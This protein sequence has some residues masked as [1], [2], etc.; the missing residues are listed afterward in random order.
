M[1]YRRIYNQIGIAIGTCPATGY[2]YLNFS[3][4]YTNSIYSKIGNASGFSYNLVQPLTRIIDAGYSFTEPRVDVKSLGEYGTITR[5]A[6]ATPPI[7]LNFSYYLMG[8]INEARM[9]FLFNTYSGN[10]P[11]N[12]LIYS[13]NICPVSALLDRTYQKNYTNSF[14]NIS[15]LNE[16]WLNNHRDCKNI[17]I[18]TNISDSDLNYL[19]TITQTLNGSTGK[20]LKDNVYVYA[21]GNC[22]L[23]NYKVT[24]AVGNFPMASVQYTCYNVM[25]QSGGSG[26]NIPSVN[27]SDFTLKTGTYNLPPM[28]TGRQATVLLPGDITLDISQTGNITSVSNLPIDF[29][30]IKIQNFD[31]ELNLNR[32]PLQNLGYKLPM[33]RRINPPIYAN[34]SFNA[35]V[36][37]LATGSFIE[38]INQ[39]IE[40]NININM[41]YSKSQQ[42]T[43]TAIKYQFL[44]AKFNCIQ[45]QESISDKRMVTCSLTSELN[46][47][48]TGRGF[49]MSGQLG[50][51]EK[52]LPSY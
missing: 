16:Y 43:G 8:L 21:F 25:F 46:P 5:P 41:K 2:H 12:P 35:T 32:E 44:S 36:G 19:P 31:L 3:G 42:I 15:G 52:N 27:S 26:N 33:D 1:S 7:S 34:L 20:V 23:D 30:D 50:I 39:D 4:E 51:T 45:M 10:N 48:L 24:A 29:S 17:F 47:N 11:S 37:D 9:G 28:Y 22:Y 14:T 6:I 40:Y 49:F 13:Y 18:P 38:F